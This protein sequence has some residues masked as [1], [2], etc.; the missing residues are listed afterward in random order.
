MLDMVDT[1]V[2]GQCNGLCCIV[3][4]L[5]RAIEVL[6]ETFGLLPLLGQELFAGL[7]GEGD[8][9]PRLRGRLHQPPLAFLNEI[10]LGRH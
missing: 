1:L 6:L 4:L 2:V 9:G 5:P 8:F 3:D 7:L 10:R